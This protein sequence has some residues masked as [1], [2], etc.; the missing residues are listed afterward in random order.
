MLEC[1]CI[2]IIPEPSE[3]L[4]IWILKI[5]RPHWRIKNC[6]TWKLNCQFCLWFNVCVWSLYCKWG[7]VV[8]M[9]L[10]STQAGGKTLCLVVPLLRRKTV[11]F[12][13]PPSNVCAHFPW[14]YGRALKALVVKERTN[15]CHV[16]FNHICTKSLLNTVHHCINFSCLCVFLHLILYFTNQDSSNFHGKRHW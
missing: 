2:W 1:V 4:F 5:K 6:K 11:F 7:S 13:F 15:K 3:T 14:P 16:S 8:S 12:F 10:N 9:R